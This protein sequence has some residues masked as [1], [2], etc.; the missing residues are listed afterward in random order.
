MPGKFAGPDPTRVSGLG[1]F[2]LSGAALVQS[3]DLQIPRVRLYWVMIVLNLT[4]TVGTDQEAMDRSR[5]VSGRD[6]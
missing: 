1:L 5:V 2:K 4:S 6:P 3:V